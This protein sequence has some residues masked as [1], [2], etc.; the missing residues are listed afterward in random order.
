LSRVSTVGDEPISEA[1]ARMMTSVLIVH[2]TSAFLLNRERLNPTPLN[3]ELMNLEP[4]KLEP[5]KLEPLI[6]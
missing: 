2:K 1:K 6:P 3:L 4:L 5:V